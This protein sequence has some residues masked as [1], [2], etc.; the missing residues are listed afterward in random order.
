M[1]R[2]GDLYRFAG[3]R[4]IEK[5]TKSNR[6]THRTDNLT[7]GSLEDGWKKASIA[8]PCYPTAAEVKEENVS[9]VFRPIEEWEEDRKAILR[10]LVKALA[11]AEIRARVDLAD[12]SERGAPGREPVRRA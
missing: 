5:R 12:Q 4:P 10:S 9:S 6:P 8:I 3:R 1:R 2:S 7:D 11:L